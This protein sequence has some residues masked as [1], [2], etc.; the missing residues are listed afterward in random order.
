VENSLDRV[1]VP[2]MIYVPHMFR[3]VKRIFRPI[4]ILLHITGWQFFG[5]PAKA[6]RLPRILVYLY[7]VKAGK[8]T[9]KAPFTGA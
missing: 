2:D 1:F 8:F 3:C 6:P 7:E 9:W 4:V 5:P